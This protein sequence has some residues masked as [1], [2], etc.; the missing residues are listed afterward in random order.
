MK[1]KLKMLLIVL[2]ALTM[3]MPTGLAYAAPTDQA[4]SA[5]DEAAVDNPLEGD[6]PI[7]IDPARLHVKKLG[8]DL[9]LD[10][11]KDKASKEIKSGKITLEEI[12]E[13]SKEELNESVRISI[14]MKDPAVL[15]KYSVKQSTGSSAKNFNLKTK[16][17]QLTVEQ[18]INKSLGRKLKVKWHLT[19]A[20][21]AISTEATYAEIAKILK[22]NG[23]DS[24]ERETRYEP[25]KA[26]TAEPNTSITSEGMTGAALTWSAGYT[27]AGQKVAIIDTGID[28]DHQSFDGDAFDYAISK[29]EGTDDSGSTDPDA[30]PID[31]PGKDVSVMTKQDVD[32]AFSSLDLNCEEFL[33]GT[34]GVYTSSKLPFTVNYVD[35]NTDVTHLNDKQGEHGSHVAGIAAANRFVKQGDEYVD[36][37]ENVLAVGMAPDAQLVVM[38]VFGV[39]GGAYDSDYMAA[40]E[41]AI[42]LGCDSCNLSLG[43]GAAGFTFDTTYQEVLNKLSS[44][45]ND[46]MVVSI[47]AGNSYSWADYNAAFGEVFLNDVNMD[48][49]GSPG[50]FVNSFTVA[51][52]INLGTTGKPLTFNGQDKVY[53]TDGANDMSS[54]ANTDGY[55]FV[56]IYSNGYAED[57]AAVNEALPLKGKIVIVNR[58]DITFAEKGTNAIPYE[59]A[60]LIVANNQPGT[61]SMALDDFKGSFPMVSITLDDAEV[62]YSNCIDNGRYGVIESDDVEVINEDDNTSDPIYVFYGKVTVSKE[63]STNV[64]GDLDTTEISDFSS[65][66]VPGSL[67]MKPEITAPGENIYSVF[68]TN[69]TANGITG[70]TDK[71]EMMSGTSMA[72]PHI[73]GLS[74]VL[75]QY[76]KENDLRE[77]NAGLEGYTDRAIAQSLLMSTAVPMQPKYDGYN[78]GYLSILQQGSGLVDVSNAVSAG[79]VVM[80]DESVPN[81]TTK[82]GAAKDGKVKI[83]LGDDPEKNGEYSYAF[84]INN[85]TDTDENFRLSTDLF[86][87][88]IDK[89]QDDYFGTGYKFNLMSKD[90]VD[91]DA[92]VTYST[93]DQVTVP[94]HGSVDVTVNIKVDKDQLNKYPKGAYIEGYTYAYC[95]AK[96]DEGMAWDHVHSIPILGFYGSWTDPSMFDKT[97]IYDAL[98]DQQWAESE[99]ELIR[100]LDIK[101]YSGNYQ[102]NFMSIRYDGGEYAFIG[103]P[104]YIEK[105]YPYERLAISS[106]TE[107][108][109]FYYNLIRPAGTLG[110]SVNK[111]DGDKAGETI[112]SAITNNL[113]EGL[114]YYVNGQSYQNTATRVA[115]VNDTVSDFGLNEGDKFRVGFYAVPEY[116]AMKAKDSMNDAFSGV[117]VDDE[118]FADFVKKEANE[119]G[120]AEGGYMRYD[121]TIDDQNPVIDKESVEFNEET[122]DIT[123]HVSDNMNVAYV[124]ALDVYGFDLYDENVP[125]APEA[126]VTMNVS[127]A[128]KAGNGYVALFAGDYAGNEAAVAIKV[129]EANVESHDV[130]MDGDTD[131]ADAQAL[132]EYITGENDG[133][134]LNLYAGDMDY[135][136]M[137]TSRDAQLL[138]VWTPEP[139]LVEYVGLDN[140]EI[141]LFKGMTQGLNVSILPITAKDKTVTWASEDE[142]IAT[143]DD[144]G[145]ITGVAEGITTITASSIPESSVNKE[146]VVAQC[147]VHVLSRDKDLNGIVWDETG[148]EFHS[149]FNTLAL[150]DYVKDA[151]SDISNTTTA[152]NYYGTP[153]VGTLDTDEVSSTLYELNPDYTSTELGPM[154]DFAL[155][156]AL[157][158]VD[159]GTPLAYTTEIAPDGNNYIGAICL[160]N[161]DPNPNYDNMT[162]LP[163]VQATFED[164]I[165]EA[166]IP[167]LAFKGTTKKTLDD[168]LKSYYQNMYIDYYTQVLYYNYYDDYVDLCDGDEDLALQYILEDGEAYGLAYYAED[169]KDDSYNAPSYY[170]VDTNGNIWLTEASM[171]YNEEYGYDD[172][173]F[174]TPVLVAETGIPSSDLYQSLY[175]DGEYL[176]WSHYDG[177]VAELYVI[178]PEKGEVYDAGNFGED[179]WPASGLYEENAL[180][181]EEISK[182]SEKDYS[183]VIAGLDTKI[184]LTDFASKAGEITKST[185][186]LDANIKATEVGKEAVAKKIKAELA[187]AV[188]GVPAATAAP[189]AVNDQTADQTADEPKTD[190]QNDN[191]KSEA[192][193]TKAK[194]KVSATNTSDAVK[195][196]ITADEA[197]KNGF[198]TVTYDPNAMTYAGSESELTYKS[199][200]ADEVFGTITF[201]Y[202]DKDYLDKDTL[203]ATVLFKPGCEDADANVLTTERNDQL[204]LN[205]ESSVTIDGEGHDWGE[206][207]WSWSKDFSTASAKFICK[208]DPNHVEILSAEVTMKAADPTCVDGVNTYTA[209]VTLEGKEYTDTAEEAVPSVDH[210]YGDPVWTWADDFS[211]AT[212]KFTC[213]FKE[214]NHEFTVTP[215]VTE[216]KATCEKA[217]SKVY[218]AKVEV[219]GKEYK[220]EKKAETKA[221]G[222]NYGEPTWTWAEDYSSATATFTCK[223]D[224]AHVKT[225]DAVVTKE[226]TKDPEC[227]DEG[228]NTY[229]AK[230]TFEGKEYTDTVN[231]TV[232]A[233][234]HEYGEPTWAWADDL[235]EAT[236]T[237]TCNNKTHKHVYTVT[238]KVTVTDPTCTKDGKKVY[239]ATIEIDGKEYK[240]DQKTEAIKATGH[241]YGDPKYTWSSTNRKVTAKMVCK[242]DSKHVVTETVK[243]TKKTTKAT[244]TKKGKTVYTAVFT[245]KAFKKQTKKVVLKAKGHKYEYKLVKKATTKHSGKLAK[246]CKNCGKKTNILVKPVV[247]KAKVMTNTKAKITWKKVNGAERY[248]VY[249]ASCGKSKVKKIATVTSGL[250]YVKS[251]LKKATTYKFKVVAQRKINGKW[252]N[253]STSYISHFVSGNLTKNKKYTNTKSLSVDKKSVTISVGKT[254]TIK[255]KATA[256]KKG[257]KLL[258]ESHVPFYRYLSSNTNIATVSSKGKIKAKK[259]GTC[260]VY[261][262][263]TNGIWKAIKVTVK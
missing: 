78:N 138:L 8:E 245:N 178:D 172:A 232:D 13:M 133:S 26:E 49:V 132:L 17:A 206:P 114:W 134:E 248:Q 220:S 162:G 189:A 228:A 12:E 179:V 34:D 80:I 108:R 247:A 60:G 118:E 52:A 4:A 124:A 204:F 56:Y 18:R 85:I 45:E 171:F 68:G 31:N 73:A 195:V 261:V 182:A 143:V 212:A 185:K 163:F 259:A 58:G 231:E 176:Y 155:D 145:I 169:Y 106:R 77:A 222:H 173:S 7:D 93:G 214:H 42:K 200:F 101:P 96:T 111:L 150:K 249:F 104:Y 238:P 43:S 262:I 86:T 149:H 167:G 72:A 219:D 94:A 208:N 196:E 39:K 55:D 230:V 201:A 159:F 188:K 110:F 175:Y 165:G 187:K 1:K 125:A 198:V 192:N 44:A 263:G 11:I 2:V 107:I 87:Q 62:I 9:D 257:K 46:G 161:K 92:D 240:S 221:T 147:V 255:A 41:D 10:A 97:S 50:S 90:T 191:S 21:N 65:W 121:I 160:G 109:D 28:V 256:V 126:D 75:L 166:M 57:Y 74:A 117:F 177:S 47:S 190:D 91:V 260:Y 144:T 241:N 237:F 154:Y 242:N 158:F 252:K 36:A 215:T 38:K 184:D 141:Y 51:S 218:V 102:T 119:G 83:E 244:C 30:P 103:N 40:I 236:A 48:T 253:I 23:V 139:T 82:T 32:K 6:G 168:N 63:A 135:D 250:S 227:L 29:V 180:A 89:V 25:Q 153:V 122:G 152:F 84:T 129:C 128:I 123:F 211:S 137:L 120:L 37:G 105:E 251:K 64:T 235:S 193:E 217:G 24:V 140:E 239:V 79:S 202:A 254:K 210:V 205:E 170:F 35:G 226:T 20:V 15:D 136:G 183:S 99:N 234:G 3:I 225:V 127:E 148:M 22:V 27:G 258:G 116:Y 95:V 186:K 194:E 130:D 209:K 88:D 59:P 16:N 207:E 14:F 223:N 156:T 70:G 81:L 131:E 229:T 142:S 197:V 76:L 66:G 69:Q 216:N 71:Y 146:A 181:G 224:P 98:Y 100:D 246:V 19:F 243:T 164:T 203:L 113:F 33:S 112:D 5:Q 151:Q 53:Y 61:I 213:N 157:G 115:S 233:S 174:S 67:I 54:L 199:I